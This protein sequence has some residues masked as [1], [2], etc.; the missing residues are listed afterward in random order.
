M[1]SS[2]YPYSVMNIYLYSKSDR[3]WPGRPVFNPR[4]RHTK[5]FENGT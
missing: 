3:Q 1:I 4:S 2:H 5:D